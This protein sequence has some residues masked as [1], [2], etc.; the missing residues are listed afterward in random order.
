MRRSFSDGTEIRF[1][2]LQQLK[3]VGAF[4]RIWDVAGQNGRKQLLAADELEVAQA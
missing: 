4:G 2:A 1:A 3:D